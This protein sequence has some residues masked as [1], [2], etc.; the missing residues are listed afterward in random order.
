MIVIFIN[1]IIMLNKSDARHKFKINLIKASCGENYEEAV[2]EWEI[3][4]DF[5][6]KNGLCI[7]QRKIN[8]IIFMFNIVN[9]NIIMVGTKC[10]KKF[11]LQI[12]EMNNNAFKKILKSIFK[13]G[14][15]KI[16]DNVVEYC[17]LAKEK[18]LKHFTEKI[19]ELWCQEYLK[20]LLSDVDNLI[21]E[22]KL[23]YL[24]DIRVLISDKLKE[25]IKTNK[26]ETAE[27]DKLI[28][29]HKLLQW[30]DKK[31]TIIEKKILEEK[32]SYENKLLKNEKFRKNKSL[33]TCECGIEYAHLCVCDVPKYELIKINGRYFCNNCGK[34]KDA[35]K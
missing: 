3:I 2:K 35:C 9:K 10:Y 20:K 7:C 27:N 23:N 18:L 24:E 13:K 32:K 19:N 22:Y 21:K 34:W 6:G 30:R 28:A 8:N 14:E 15:Y 4:Q 5:K 16:V 17:N 31:K 29:Q 26:E 11:N 33:I 12:N 1:I 25:I